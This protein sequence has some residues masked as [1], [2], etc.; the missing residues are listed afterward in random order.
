MTKKPNARSARTFVLLSFIAAAFVGLLVGA[1]TQWDFQRTAIWV[2][3]TF[4]V[5][6]VGIATLALLVKD[7]EHDPEV[8]KLK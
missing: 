6:I 3:I 8:P 7:D 5:S 4:I 2:G 1:A